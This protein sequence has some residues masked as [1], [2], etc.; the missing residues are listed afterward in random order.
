VLRGNPFVY[1]RADPF[2]HTLEQALG[3]LQ[4]A[5]LVIGHRGEL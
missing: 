4:R 1:S 5:I 3:A 2:E